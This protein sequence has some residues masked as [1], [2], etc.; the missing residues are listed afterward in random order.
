MSAL[1]TVPEVSDLDILDD[2]RR[3][4]RCVVCT[5]E[6]GDLIGVPFVAI[7]GKRAINLRAWSNPD[8]FPPDACPECVAR[9]DH[10]CPT[11]G[12]SQ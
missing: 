10:D 4:A 11:C 12:G 8:A 6:R 2:S 1:A 5:N 7:C 3:H 9:F